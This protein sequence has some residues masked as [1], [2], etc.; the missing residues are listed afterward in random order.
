MTSK[1]KTTL[2]PQK[3]IRIAH[4][5]GVPVQEDRELLSALGQIETH[6]APRVHSV[7]A[8]LLQFINDIDTE[9]RQMHPSAEDTAC[10]AS[11]IINS[12]PLHPP[13]L[14]DLPYA[15]RRRKPKQ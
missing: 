8:D 11:P 4:R 6:Q 15:P 9:Y 13:T 3:V 7:V 14:S 10:D 12:N 2:D 5:H 1:K